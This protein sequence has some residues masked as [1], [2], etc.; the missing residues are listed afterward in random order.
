MQR[1]V[2]GAGADGSGLTRPQLWY[3]YR[4]YPY[5]LARI[6]LAAVVLGAIYVA[7]HTVENVLTPILLSLLIAYLL[8]P[9]IDWLEERGL[10]RTISIL[11]FLG[12]GAICVLLFGLFL[13]PTI[14]HQIVVISERLPRLLL[15][16][17]TDALPWVQRT[18]GVELPP[19]LSEAMREY[20]ATLQAQLPAVASKASGWMAG[21]WARTGSLVASLLNLVMIPV[22]TF[23]FL[24]DFDRIRISTVDYIPL[25]YREVVL[26]RVRLMDEVVGA[27]FRGQVEV[28]VILAVLYALGLSIVFGSFGFGVTSGVAIGLLTGLLNIV[29]YFGFLIGFVLSIAVV[30]IDWHGWVPVVAVLAVFASVQALEGYVI[31]P[32]VVGE[33]V[34]LSPVVVIIVLLLG[35]EVLGLLG[36]LL[37]IPVAGIVR[38]LLPDFVALYRR[39]NFF[40]GELDTSHEATV[41]PRQEVP[42]L[43]D[44]AE[45]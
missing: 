27:W 32:R 41:A 3:H 15:L 36:V 24:R 43:S 13:Y 5:L 38:V 6:V 23:Y 35:G 11:C 22:F 31:T 9:A 16:L 19:T 10:E 30:L 34:G 37:A 17:Q 39:S 45:E 44:V 33:K 7:L 40:T 14:A 21:L 28:A 18:I 25:P 42:L 8:D 2:R 29:P 20:G 12:T 26:S 1:D 4:R